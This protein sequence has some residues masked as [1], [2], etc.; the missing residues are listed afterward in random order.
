MH[1]QR[2][3]GESQPHCAVVM[4]V[5]RMIDFSERYAEYDTGHGTSAGALEMLAGSYGSYSVCEA[6]PFRWR[7]YKIARF[8]ENSEV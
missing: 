3:S 5:Q 4:E 2:R 8:I 7:G 1:E 6:N